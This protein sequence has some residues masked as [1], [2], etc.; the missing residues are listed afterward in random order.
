MM[1]RLPKAQMAPIVGVDDSNL[2]HRYQRQ[3]WAATEVFHRCL[4]DGTS[5]LSLSQNRFLFF[6]GSKAEAWGT[7]R[8][9]YDDA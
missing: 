3:P 9:R 6:V 2:P 1:T 5:S 4:R 8:L 7:E